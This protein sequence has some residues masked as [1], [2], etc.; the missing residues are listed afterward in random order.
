MSS[1]EKEFNETSQEFE[2]ERKQNL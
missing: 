1:W 2:T